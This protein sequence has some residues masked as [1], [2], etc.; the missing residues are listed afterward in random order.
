MEKVAFIHYAYPP[1]IGG[2]ETLL[3]EY[4]KELVDRNFSVS[5]IVG[6]GNEI[7]NRID[8]TIE[9]SF[10]SLL[11]HDPSLYAEIVE[12]G[13]ITDS[14]YNLASTIYKKLEKLL[15]DKD[16]IIIHN[17]ITLYHN[18]PFT[19]AFKQYVQKYGSKKKFIVW[20]HDHTYIGFDKI[21]TNEFHLHPLIHQLLTEKLP[22]VLYIAIS[23]YVKKQLMKVIPLEKNDIV[24]IPNGIY[25]SNFLNMSPE[26]WQLITAKK[27]FAHFPIALSPVNILERKNI[28]YSLHV[29]AELKKTYPMIIYVITGSGSTHRKSKLYQDYIDHLVHELGLQNNVFMLGK[30]VQRYLTMNEIRSIYMLSDFVLYFSKGEN[31]GLPILEAGITKTPIFTSNLEVFKE[32]GGDDIVRIDIKS[33]SPEVAKNIIVKSITNSR[34]MRLAHKTRSTYNLSEII[35][36]KLLPLIQS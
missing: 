36:T 10:R 26:I 2:V 25:I 31:F 16:V 28:E 32:I 13:H 6:S 4:A 8:L 5:V 11:Q 22:N 23:D 21:R 1:N 34:V 33:H 29:V 14:F 17:M 9:P 3:H 15:I 7:D 27:I 19:Y 35:E 30:N 18:M 20:V 12:H 24:V